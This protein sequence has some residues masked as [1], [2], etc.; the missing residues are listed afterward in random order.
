MS[1]DHF[2]YR[3]GSITIQ[4]FLCGHEITAKKNY[5]AKLSVM[6]DMCLPFMF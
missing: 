5:I 3:K 1:V 2:Q 4:I 6:K